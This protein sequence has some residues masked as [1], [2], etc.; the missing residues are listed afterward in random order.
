MNE[1]DVR[2]GRIP[3]PWRRVGTE[4]LIAR[5]GRQDVDS[6][7][8]AA[9]MVWLLLDRPSTMEEMLASAAVTGIDRSGLEDRV[10]DAANSLRSLGVLD[11]VTYATG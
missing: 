11:E 1:Q 3:V 4:V 7:Q 10:R 6:L 9:A 2:L 5:P 8:G